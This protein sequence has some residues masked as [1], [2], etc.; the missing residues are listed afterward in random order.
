MRVDVLIIGAG[1]IGGYLATK[2]VDSGLD[3]LMIEEHEEVGRPFQCAGLVTPDAMSK[4]GL[5]S[6]ILS[7]VWGARIHSPKGTCV[8][9]G[10]EGEIRTHVVCRKLF[11]E[12]VVRQALAKG[13]NL[14][15]DS[16]PVEAVVTN[17]LVSV[18]VN[19]SG[20]KRVIEAA[21][22]CGA[23][24]A[25]SWVRRY[26]KMG[27]PKE[28][29]IGF[30]S[31]IVGYAG[32][33]GRLDMFTGEEVAPGLFAWAIPS[34]RGW[35][36][37]VWSRPKDMKG[38]SSEQLYEALITH[39]RWK[40]R[41]AGA[42][43]VARYCGPLPCGIISKPVKQRIALFGDA[44]GLCKPTTGGGIGKGFDQIDAMA[45]GLI[46][47]VKSDKLSESNLKRVA[48]PLKAMKKEQ[49]RARILRDLFLTDCD[50]EKLEDTFTIFSKPE[51]LSL[52][53]EFGEIEKPVALGIKMLKEVPEFR[54][55]AVG[56]TWAL[57]RGE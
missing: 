22:L 40:E 51:V 42:H 34:G 26:F 52:I 21:L 14:W 50:D 49:K 31:E 27:N 4:V 45:E 28:L 13:A 25:H 19:K 57:L 5:E 11:D 23:D 47:A 46:S 33:P 32:A 35:R 48:K 16:Q 17:S 41:F 18:T 10:E 24:G 39:P 53:N 55:M 7:S 38:R 2:L 1:P 12:G 36:V 30:Q 9:V 54:R 29:M 3:V 8:E 15:L 6:S 20:E 43:E 56:A 44:V 37:G